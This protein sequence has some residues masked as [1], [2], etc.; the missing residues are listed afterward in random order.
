MRAGSEGGEGI[1]VR[2]HLANVRTLLA[3]TRLAVAILGVAYVIAKLNLLSGPQGSNLGAT[4][5]VG[6]AA[7]VAAALVA[8][9]A[10]NRFLVRRSAI[11]RGGYGPDPGRDLVL[12]AITGAGGLAVMAY[13]VMVR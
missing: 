3:W 11:E 5:M 7:G 9:V 2:D 1:R 8:L 12:I 6:P 13:L 10:L 4:G